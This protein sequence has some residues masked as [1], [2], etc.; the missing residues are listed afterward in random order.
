MQMYKVNILRET[1]APGPEFETKSPALRADALPLS[2]RAHTTDQPQMFLSIHI[3]YETSRRVKIVTISSGDR[4]TYGDFI[5]GI[6][7]LYIK[8]TRRGLEIE[9]KISG[10][11]V[12]CSR[13]AQW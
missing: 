1:F 6:F 2:N 5:K 8:L 12:V 4:P 13:V 11:S 9:R 10:W 7:R 3:P